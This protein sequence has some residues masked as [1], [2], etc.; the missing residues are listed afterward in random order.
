MILTVKSLTGSALPVFVKTTEVIPTSEATFSVTVLAV[1]S[2]ASLARVQ[3]TTSVD[4][5]SPA[6]TPSK[7]TS[8]AD[9]AALKSTTKRRVF[10]KIQ[11]LMPC[12]KTLR[13]MPILHEC[14]G[15]QEK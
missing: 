14:A 10:K 12:E 13:D 5:G 1:G 4:V 7:V 3:S 11:G 6:A 9:A 2:A 15:A 8:L